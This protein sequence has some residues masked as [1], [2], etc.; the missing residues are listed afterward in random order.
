M[1]HVLSRGNN[2]DRIFLDRDDRETFLKTLGQA[3]ERSGWV[4]HAYVLMD[5]HYH[6]LLE[7]PRGGLVDGMRWLQTAYTA[8]FHAWH[9]TCGHVFQGRYKAVLVQPDAPEYF[10]RVGDYIHLNPARARLLKGKSPL[11]E[12]F[13]FSSYPAYAQ[14]TACPPWLNTRRL[15]EAH[16]M[17][18]REY[19][20]HL[21]TRAIE[22]MGP[23]T[24]HQQEWKDLRR[25]WYLGEEAFRED[26]QE[27]ISARVASGKRESYSGEAVLGHDEKAAERR[28]QAGLEALRLDAETLQ[29]LQTT[30]VRKQALAWLIRSSTLVPGGWIRERLGMK[31]RSNIS[32]AVKRF[33]N[34]SGAEEKALK[35]KMRQCKD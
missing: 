3:C 34:A 18:A 7:T 35:I 31:H 4:V 13:E 30:D 14:K 19:R 11:L 29:Q 33:E 20:Q 24:D 26:M 2:K 15:L 12:A 6:L 8:R 27:R 16:A 17:G 1:Y 5:N 10:R 28:F 21:Q 9:G 32:R 25:G 22:A 23:Q